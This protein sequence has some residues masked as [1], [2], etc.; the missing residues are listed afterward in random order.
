MKIKTWGILF[1]IFLALGALIT[2]LCFVFLGNQVIRESPSFVKVECIDGKFYLISDF[3]FYK[4]CFKLEQKVGE[5]FIVMDTV[6]SENNIINLSE[7]DFSIVPGVVYRFSVCYATESGAGNSKFSPTIEWK[8][9]LRLNCV[10]YLSVHLENDVLGW[11]GVENADSYSLIFV[12][13][14]GNVNTDFADIHSTSVSVENLGVGG[15]KL[16]I[17]AKNRQIGFEDSYAG[18][19]VEICISRKN[20]IKNVSNVQGQLLVTCSQE[21]SQ[22]ELY[23]EDLLLGTFSAV[24]Y[25]S[26]EYIYDL[27]EIKVILNNLKTHGKIYLKSASNGYVLESE[28]FLLN[29]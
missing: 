5:D 25:G 23:D 19:G 12:D 28:M 9:P 3:S 4:Y 27:N 10:D 14:D 17:I 13:R 6:E 22:F 7:Q 16:F 26:E 1:A 29:L 21:V 2:T 8:P 15:Y 24:G 18:E 20:Q 11:E